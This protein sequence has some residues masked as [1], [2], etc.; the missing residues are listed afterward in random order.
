MSWKGKSLY[1]AIT[2]V[3]S[4]MLSNHN[5]QELLPLW[6]PTLTSLASPELSYNSSQC[7]SK[8][9]GLKAITTGRTKRL[10]MN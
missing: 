7:Q 1:T 4:K 3:L 6:R 2:K 5:L 10:N 9:S 8:E